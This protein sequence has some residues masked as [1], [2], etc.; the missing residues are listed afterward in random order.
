MIPTELEKIVT[1]KITIPAYGETESLNVAIS[2]A[3]ILDN[4]KRNL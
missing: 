3:V 2:T 1:K 4:W